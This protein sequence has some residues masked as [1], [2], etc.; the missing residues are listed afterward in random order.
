MLEDYLYEQNLHWQGQQFDA[1]TERELLISLLPFMELDHILAI[2]GIRR[3]GKSYLMKQLINDLLD[4]GTPPENIFFANLELPGFAGR[5]AAEVLHELWDTFITLKNP[6]GKIYFFLD[7]IQTLQKWEVWVKYY[8][9]LRKGDLKFVIT[10]SN[11]Q[12][13]SSELATLLSGRV[14]EKKLYPFSLREILR[15]QKIDFESSEGRSLNRNQIRATFNNY[16]QEGGMPE[17]LSVQAPETKRELLTTYF[18]TIIYKDIISRFSVRHSRLLKDLAIYLTGQPASLINMKK[19]ADIFQSNRTILKEFS[20][21]LQLSFFV[22][23]LKKFDYSAQKREMALRKGFVVDNGFATFL[24]IRF[25]P[26]KG[27]LLENLVCVELVRRSNEVFYWKNHNECD[28]IIYDPRQGSQAIQVCY[29]LDENNR[30]R[31]LAGLKAGCDFLK[32]KEGLIL[33]LNQKDQFEY[34]GL[35]VSVMPA[36][37]WL[38]NQ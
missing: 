20:F 15:F 37:Q 31:E 24:P 38:L 17:L 23:F 25:S 35:T 12:L 5:P 1:G 21:F 26:D 8:Y 36:Y 30:G 18:N 28:F 11:S 27:K 7:E 13:L 16:F 6:K 14:I 29:I 34:K 10:G 33:T 3:C 2:S 22:M 19:L 4:K 9:D 32:L